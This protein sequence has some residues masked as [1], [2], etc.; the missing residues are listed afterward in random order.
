MGAV[1]NLCRAYRE[2]LIV[3]NAGKSNIVEDYYKSEDY[4]PLLKRLPELHARPDGFILVGEFGG[5]VVACGMTHRIG[6]NTCEIKRVFVS[7]AARGHG[8]AVALCRAAMEQA[9]KDGYARM[10]LDTMRELPE[11]IALYRKLGFTECAPF[12]D[13][14]PK[15]THQ[16]HFFGRDI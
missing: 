14:D 16:I 1:R 15:Y 11:A 12:Y 6:P 10:V 7:D 2:L 13:P 3:R 5:D 9:A 4:E 8:V